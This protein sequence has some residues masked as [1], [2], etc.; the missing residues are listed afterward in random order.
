KCLDLNTWQVKW[1]ESGM[2]YGTVVR[3][4]RELLG[5]ACGGEL[6]RVAAA[7]E[8]YQEVERTKVMK[9]PD[10]GYRLPALSGGRLFVRDDDT[11]RCLEVGPE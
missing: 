11:L 10:S 2:E 8:K 7:A 9:A 5:L 1:E 3:V 6:I 4:D